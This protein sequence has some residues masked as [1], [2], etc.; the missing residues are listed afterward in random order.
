[1]E[2]LSKLLLTNCIGHICKVIYE[3]QI[4]MQYGESTWIKRGSNPYYI[5]PINLSLFEKQ[6]S[7]NKW[8][9]LGTGP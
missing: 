3:H 6:K 4:Y 5:K 9:S 2:K 8:Y 1:M 7:I